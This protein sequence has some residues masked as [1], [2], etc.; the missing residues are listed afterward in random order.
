ML[1]WAHHCVRWR[2]YVH[3]KP[4]SKNNDME[5]WDRSI[6]NIWPEQSNS[7]QRQCP[8]VLACCTYGPGSIDPNRI[9][10]ASASSPQILDKLWAR[11]QENCLLTLCQWEYPIVGTIPTREP[12]IESGVLKNVRRRTAG[13][14][15]WSRCSGVGWEGKSC[16]SGLDDSLHSVR[17]VPEEKDWILCWLDIKTLR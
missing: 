16:Y 7:N 14:D 12:G 13:W 9:I 1:G 6:L 11:C 10:G 8:S 17:K 2:W 15:K 5:H 3:C 4:T